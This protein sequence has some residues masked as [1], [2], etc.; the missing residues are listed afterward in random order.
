MPGDVVRRLI[1]GKDTQRGYCRH[2]HVKSDLLVVGSKQV[3][4][5][6]DSSQLS[7]VEVIHLKG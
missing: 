3:I 4:C 1:K 7:P 2:I 6:V 5:Q